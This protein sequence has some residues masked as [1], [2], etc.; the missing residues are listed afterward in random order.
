M[1]FD[2]A[3][4]EDMNEVNTLTKKQHHQENHQENH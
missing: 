4:P 2:I 1:N 3:L